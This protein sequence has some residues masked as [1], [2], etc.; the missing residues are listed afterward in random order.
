LPDKG[1]VNI[2]SVLRRHPL[3]ATLNNLSMRIANMRINII[4]PDDGGWVQC[5]PGGK[6]GAPDFCQIM[7]S[8]PEGAKQCKVCHVLMTVAACSSG[9]M[10]QRCH[11][12]AHTLV[13][14]VNPPGHELSQAVL[15]TCTF[16]G[17]DK[18]KA[19]KE[20][21]IRGKHLGLD[22]K[23]LKKH[24]EALPI[25]TEPE[26]AATN[27]LLAIAAESIKLIFSQRRLQE[28]LIAETRGRVRTSGSAG[29]AVTAKLKVLGAESGEETKSKASRQNR[30]PA[31]IGVVQETVNKRP[32]F[33]YN[34]AEI[35]AAA[36]MTPN[37]FSSLFRRHTGQTFSDFVATRRLAMAKQLLSDFT[38]SIS[39]IASKVGFDDPGYFAR[40]FRK[41]EGCTPRAWRE[42]L[43]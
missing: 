25:L 34:V 18:K 4:Y 13:C 26:I 24:F 35:A 42:S 8:V 12:G 15:S 19:W 40:R 14:P 36:R 6:K 20:T 31:L 9:T 17:T 10:Q 33:H 7:Q 3:L 2:R 30:V 1:S 28:Q 29:N 38:L 11:A 39:E 22:L 41:A 37:H 23:E 5:A 16:T 21:E 27:D 43:R 32:D